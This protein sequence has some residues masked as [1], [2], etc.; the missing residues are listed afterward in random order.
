MT[1]MIVLG[2]MATLAPAPVM[3]QASAQ[4]AEPARKP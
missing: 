4:E 1:V 3:G 2:A